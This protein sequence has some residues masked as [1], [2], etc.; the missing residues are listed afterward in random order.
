MYRTVVQRRM[1]RM[2]DNVYIDY[3]KDEGK[4]RESR[5]QGIA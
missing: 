5:S 1:Y 4:K 3:K 2:T